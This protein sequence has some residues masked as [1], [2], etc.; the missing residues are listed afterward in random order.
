MN[1]LITMTLTLTE[2]GNLS[3]RLD[4]DSTVAPAARTILQLGM[5]EVAKTITQGG[6]KIGPLTPIP[7]EGS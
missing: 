4:F 6:M 7:A 1:P 3:Q 2:D 5:L